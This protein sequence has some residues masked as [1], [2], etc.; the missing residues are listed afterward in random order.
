METI[1]GIISGIRGPYKNRWAIL[2]LQGGPTVTGELPLNLSLGDRCEIEGTFSTHPTYG[3]QLKASRITVVAPAD[4]TG[5]ERF[6]QRVLSGVGPSIA[7][8]LIAKF[9]N[10]ETVVRMIEHEPDKLHSV[11]GLSA[12]KIDRI[13]EDWKSAKHHRVFDEF[14]SRANISP[15]LQEKLLA[16]YSTPYNAMTQIQA[17]PYVLA[18]DVWGVGFKKADLVASY[19]SVPR[20]EGK[21]ISRG[22]FYA[23]EESSKEGHCYLLKEEL[24]KRAADLLQIN[25]SLIEEKLS[26][27]TGRNRIMVDNGR[28]YTP[29]MYAAETYVAE[30]LSRML[31]PIHECAPLEAS[32]ASYSGLGDDQRAALAMALKKR[33]LVITGGPGVGKT[34]TLNRIL[35]ALS[36]NFHAHNIDLAAP[37]GKAAKRMQESTGKQA[38][39][40]H[41]LLAY[42]PIF[43]QFTV[44]DQNPLACQVLIIDECSMIDIN[45]MEALLRAIPD[46]GCRL[47][48]VGDK[49]QL[50][51]V[52][53]GKV[54][55]DIIESGRVPVVE[56]KKLYRQAEASLI[57]INAQLIN[58]GKSIET[59][60][61]DPDSDF[62]TI[63]EDDVEKIPQTI[64]TIC[65]QIPKRFPIA[66]DDIQILC[67]QRIGKIGTRELNTMLRD[68]IFN[69]DGIKISGTGFLV[70]DRIIQTRNNYNLEV[71]NGDIGTIRGANDEALVID[72]DGM[73][74]QYPRDYLDDIELAY[75]LTIHKSQGSEFPCVIMPIHTSNYIMLKRNLFYTGITRGK[76]MVVVVGSQKAITVATRTVDSKNRNTAL[77][78]KLKASEKGEA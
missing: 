75:A 76:Q 21:R 16:A 8:D 78:E 63:V 1:T 54:F 19:L 52:G 60:N 58:A 38:V 59:R 4:K 5:E 41:R 65:R 73:A 77:V 53:P 51:S 34:Y 33:I 68:E 39:T 12:L 47:I 61:N 30:K 13:Q 28:H 7:K 27:L 67:P 74:I 57:H 72:F 56:L 29:A 71:F 35:F 62:W 46:D 48:L 22:I 66:T 2:T 18:D 31:S 43:N 6:L 45:L 11:R 3:S 55:G 70:G 40:L 32:E 69:P 9:G 24:I 26:R 64:S 14:C 37:T 42:S 15:N 50:P 17:D 25:P 20:T 23:L 36:E 49:D 44:N 10:L